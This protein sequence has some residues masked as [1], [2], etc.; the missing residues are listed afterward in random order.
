L[1]ADQLRSSAGQLVRYARREPRRIEP[2]AHPPPPNSHRL[3]SSAV[4]PQARANMRTTSSR[5][6]RL[7]P[8]RMASASVLLGTPLR[9]RNTSSDGSPAH[10]FN[11][12]R[13]ATNSSTVPADVGSGAD[14]PD[15]PPYGSWAL[16]TL[17]R[18]GAKGPHVHEPTL[19]RTPG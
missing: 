17:L 8:T 2:L 13:Q 7:R 3:T 4:A 6:S 10:T 5:G 14:R 19:Q 12:R 15:L 11:R 1:A 16:I 18:L 9:R